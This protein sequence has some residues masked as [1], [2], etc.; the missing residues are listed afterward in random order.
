MGSTPD[1]SRPEAAGPQ[2][3]ARER[4]TR[5]AYLGLGSNVGDRLAH[6]QNAVD[7]LAAAPGVTVAA[8]SP[9]YETEPVGGPSQGDYLNAVVALH[10]DRT[11]RELLELARR[12][13]VEAGR[14][15]RERWGPRTLDVDVLIVGHELVDE[16]DLVVPHPRLFERHFVLAPL[17]DLEPALAARPRQ[18]WRGVRRVEVALT[19]PAT[20]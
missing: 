8:V 12:L 9:V 4:E 3:R 19:P 18:G 11:A 2:G 10:T 14:E 13:E 15:R 5:R 17:A 20:Q 7:G 16:P 1:E 6:L